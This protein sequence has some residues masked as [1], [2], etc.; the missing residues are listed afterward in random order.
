MRGGPPR[1]R[2][3]A[4]SYDGS[5][6]CGTIGGRA[7]SE[8]TP[9]LRL[10]TLQPPPAARKRGR[11]IVYARKSGSFHRIR[12][13]IGGGFSLKGEIS[14]AAV[15]GTISPYV[16]TY[17]ATINWQMASQ[18]LADGQEGRANPMG[19]PPFSFGCYRRE[20]LP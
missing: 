5:K 7:P 11:I 20:G 10:L 15:G 13:S 17:T 9:S 14:G 16:R 2:R 19:S 1:N 12:E 6:T 8:S 4:A 3:R 18:L